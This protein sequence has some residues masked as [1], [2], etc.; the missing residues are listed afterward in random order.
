MQMYRQERESIAEIAKFLR[1]DSHAI[2]ARLVKLRDANALLEKE[3]EAAN[4]R[5]AHAELAGI[6]ATKKISS[7]GLAVY[8][9]RIVVRDRKD[10]LAYADL[11]RDKMETGAA[12][13]GAV[14]DAKPALICIVTQ[15]AVARGLHAGKLVGACAAII[16]GK[17]GGRPN[18]A[19]AGGVETAKLDDAIA[20]I[21][22]L[23]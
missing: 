10:L 16:G 8:A 20:H 5:L 6:L 4:N 22:T 17:G 7:S 12:I 18:T 19:Q 13:L 1:C 3:L 9:S 11:L 23:L 2:M 15:D 21:Y 14:L